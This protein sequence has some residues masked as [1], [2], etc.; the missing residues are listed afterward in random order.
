MLVGEWPP[1][2]RLACSFR[3]LGMEG[4]RSDGI[5][6]C[7]LSQLLILV[8]KSCALMNNSLEKLYSD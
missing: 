7:F 4:E 1:G 3:R 5:Q 6:F 8:K 2:E